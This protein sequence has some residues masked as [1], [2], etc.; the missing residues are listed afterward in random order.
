MKNVLFVL[1]VLGLSSCGYHIPLS[2]SIKF[3][4]VDTTEILNLEHPFIQTNYLVIIKMD[5]SLYSAKVNR[6]GVLYEITRKLKIK[7]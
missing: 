7:I 2:D 3:Q 1:L 6:F 4:V 5:S